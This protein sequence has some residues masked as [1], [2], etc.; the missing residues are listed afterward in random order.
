L[1]DQL[2]DT[3]SFLDSAFTGEGV[4]AQGD[5]EGI[6]RH[7]TEIKQLAKLCSAYRGFVILP[8]GCETDTT[9]IT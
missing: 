6:V 4:Q 2:Y 9:S 7:S 1:V 8:S 5:T 3:L